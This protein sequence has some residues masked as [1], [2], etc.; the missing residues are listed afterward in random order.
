[1]SNRLTYF[2]KVNMGAPMPNGGVCYYDADRIMENA[3]LI[4]VAFPN[5]GWWWWQKLRQLTYLIK[6]FLIIQRRAYFIFQ[7]PIY[8]RFGRWLIKALAK[9][10]Q[11]QPVCF[12]IDVDGVRDG[13]TELLHREIGELK[14][15]SYFIAPNDRMKKWLLNLVPDAKITT[16]DFFD[17]LTEPVPTQR[18]KNAS[19]VFAGNLSKSSFI[20]QLDQLQNCSNTSFYIYGQKGNVL[21]PENNRIHYKGIIDPYQLPW[22]LTASFGLVW[23]GDCLDC[24]CGSNGEYLKYYTPHKLSSYIIGAMPVI[25]PE[26]SASGD[27]VK[28]YKI[29][30]CIN[31]LHEIE[32]TITDLSKEEYEQ[33][34][35]NTRLLAGKIST[36]YCLQTAINN[37]LSE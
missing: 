23:D 2:L 10:K 15:F 14:Q 31:S 17:F 25:A 35:A 3:G 20:N 21:V 13:S 7:F 19:V 22:Q 34:A 18:T 9:Y 26:N 11:I 32:K 4:P 28:K 5:G 24:C 12:V 33:M 30:I 29:G 1:M 8:H 36:G 27:L 37:L 6:S 16:I